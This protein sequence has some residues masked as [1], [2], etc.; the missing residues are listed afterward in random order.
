MRNCVAVVRL[1]RSL[2]LVL[3]SR[4]SLGFNAGSACGD[5]A[6][7]TAG[8]RGARGAG[9][10][11]VALVHQRLRLERRDR[12]RA[13]LDRAA[14]LPRRRR[15]RAPRLD[16]RLARALVHCKI[17]HAHPGHYEEGG[18]IGE[19]LVPARVDLAR[20]AGP[21]RRARDHR[22]RALGTFQLS[23]AAPRAPSP[24]SSGDVGR[25]RRGHGDPGRPKRVCFARAPVPMTCSKA[26]KPGCTAASSRTAAC[27]ADGMVTLELR[28]ERLARSGGLPRSCPRARE[29]RRSSSRA[30]DFAQ[31]LRLR[32]SKKAAAYAFSTCVNWIRASDEQAWSSALVS[33]VFV[34]AGCELGRS[35]RKRQR[36]L[37]RLG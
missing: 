29:A 21:R 1:P 16:G 34:A 8:A 3:S 5:A 25:D 22:E 6:D 31:G 9:A 13:A 32:G 2:A 10:G 15:G 11:R 12:T 24:P 23:V 19:M 28:L 7:S 36:E 26:G 33:L 37:H 4:R 35:G 18:T 20:R 17:A 30:T 14:T 27:G